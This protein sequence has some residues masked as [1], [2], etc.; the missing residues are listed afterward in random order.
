M[1]I[2]VLYLFFWMY[3]AL[4]IFSVS[5]LESLDT[6]KGALYRSS[7][8]GFKSFQRNSIPAVYDRYNMD[9]YDFRV[10]GGIHIFHFLWNLQFLFYLGHIIVAGALADWYFTPRDPVTLKKIRKKMSTLPLCLSAGRSIRYHLGTVAVSS[11]IIAIIQMI[12]L[13]VEYLHNKTKSVNGTPN[14]LQK[15]LFCLIRCCLKCAE[16]CMD[17]INKNSLI[18]TA[19]FGD[20]FAVATCSA[21]ALLWRNL[22]RV[23]AIHMVD[24]IIITIGKLTVAF[25]T[26]G[27]FGFAFITLDKYK[28]IISTPIAPCIAIFILSLTV[29]KVFFVIFETVV[30]TTF[31]CFLVDSSHNEKGQMLASPGLQKLVGKYEKLSKR[32][33]RYKQLK[34]GQSVMDLEIEQLEESERYHKK[35]K[36]KK[37]H[38]SESE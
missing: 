30:D 4:Y 14:G 33:A 24:K 11:L 35:K 13:I 9:A 5:E 1:F 37:H 10:I 25:I 12:R 21:F 15:V 36:S 32:Q 29:A 27:M 31:F 6:P 17:K 7:D 34:H 2:A 28:D 19:I 22:A 26:M 3:G 23:A 8:F 20:S 38:E 18:W 16:C